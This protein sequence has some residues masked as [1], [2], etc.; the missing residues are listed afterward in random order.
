[1]SLKFSDRSAGGPGK[2]T[3]NSCLP[4]IKIISLP[5]QKKIPGKKYLPSFVGKPAIAL[6]CEGH[7]QQ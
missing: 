5:P 7:V 1:M 3:E 4:L 6:K 2:A